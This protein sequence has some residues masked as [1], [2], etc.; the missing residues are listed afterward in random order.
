[1][2]MVQATG[3][4]RRSKRREARTADILDAA[5]KLVADGGLEALTIHRLAEDLGYVPGAL[6]NYFPSKDAIVA[7]LQR[8]TVD[9]LH[10]RFRA[11]QANPIPGHLDAR[12]QALARLLG[13][14]QFYLDL[15]RHAPEEFRL[16]G[17]LLGDPRPLV[18]DADAQRVA[19]AFGA[20]L[21]DVGALFAG[22]ASA[23]A[24][25][26][27]DASA[28]TLVLWASLHGL[29]QLDK[30][31]RFDAARFDVQRLGATSVTALLLGWGADAIA[32][33][34]ARRAVTGGDKN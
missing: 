1:M 4:G 33:E 28:R 16:I 34:R 15:P 24:L 32:L 10:A 30:L 8:R 14:S 26:G 17:L 11:A 9:K 31:A 27:G 18:A 29:C 13:A 5:M 20:F 25:A 21:A 19:G 6:Y 2:N 22:A 12:G 3:A 23:G 7:A